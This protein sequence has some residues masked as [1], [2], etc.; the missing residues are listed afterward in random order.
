MS[1][2]FS[3]VKI[4]YFLFFIFLVSI[5]GFRPIGLDKDSKN[6]ADALD[7]RISDASLLDK[8]PFFWL[9]SEAS[10]LF[11]FGHPA[12]F[13]LF[14]AFI[15]VFLKLVAIF[16]FSKI[17]LLSLI[18]YVF[19]Y[20]ILHE[21]TQIRVGVSSAFFLLAIKDYF[22]KN[23]LQYLLKVLFACM[24]HYSAVLSLVL[25]ALRRES[26]SGA[27]SVFFLC[28]SFFVGHFLADGFLNKVVG[29]LPGF[30]GVRLDLYLT[31]LD[32]GESPELNRFNF[33]YAS[34][35]CFSI[36]FSLHHKKIK[37]CFDLFL[38]K[39]FNLGVFSF[40]ILSFFPVLAFRVSE[41][42]LV[43]QL[44]LLAN[45]SFVFKQKE[46]YVCFVLFFGLLMF[47]SQGLMKNIN[48]EVLL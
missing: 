18:L 20:F 17:P 5:A 43:V 25:P 16:R 6:Y 40:Y 46:F 44:V 9:I 28:L 31:M 39:V 4:Y 30:L 24:F 41:F 48:F 37:D 36:F 34:L 14:F 3:R 12:S 21:M 22:N 7:V 33:Y 29:F 11:F 45:L 19:L 35:L 8:E 13:F 38:L 15:G 32:S 1:F 10:R 27:Y 2:V 26:F 42:Y 23:I 47:V